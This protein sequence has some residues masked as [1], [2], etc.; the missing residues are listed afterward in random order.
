M[1]PQ[2]RQ[3]RFRPHMPAPRPPYYWFPAKTRGWGWGPPNGFEGWLV[4]VGFVGLVF[5]SAVTTLPADRP[6]DF[7]F[8]T[9]LLVGVLAFVIWWKGEPPSWKSGP[10]K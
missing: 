8:L 3:E 10:K 6:M 1:E 4:I 7:L 2:H 5:A 9:G